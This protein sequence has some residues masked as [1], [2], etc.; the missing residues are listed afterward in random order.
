MT[1]TEL[2]REIAYPVTQAAMVLALLFFYVLLLLVSRAGLPGVFL[3]V[4]AAPAYA[5]YLL[6]I[7]EA[8]LHGRQPEPPTLE[9]FSL[10]DSLWSLFPLVPF[11][12]LLWLEIFLSA[13]QRSGASAAMSAMLPMLAFALLMPAFLTILTMTRSPLASINPLL[14]CRPEIGGSEKFAS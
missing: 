9:M 5:R 14:M 8:R 1:P 4:V 3:L 7:L 6:A 13:G 12:A 2:A 11:A 10:V